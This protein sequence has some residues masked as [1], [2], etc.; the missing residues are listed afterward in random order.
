MI[1]TQAVN[2]AD[3]ETMSRAEFDALP[4]GMIQ[5]DARGVI[6]K[7]NAKEAEIARRSVD[8]TVGKNFFTDIAPCTNVPGF[9]GHF[10]RLGQNGVSDA[11]F[12]FDFLFPWGARRVA[13]KMWVAASGMRYV[14]V[15][16]L[17]S[18]AR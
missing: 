8:E 11:N 16:P 5:M 6:L 12:T 3:V 4:V 2:V 14:M 10:D 15:T 18:A 7:Y 13:I 1:Q 9:R 17:A